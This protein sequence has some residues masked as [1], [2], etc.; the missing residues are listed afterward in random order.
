MPADRVGDTRERRLPAARQDG[1][2]PRNRR[3]QIAAAL[4]RLARRLPEF[5]AEAVIDS[6]LASQGLRGA[7]PETAARL[8]LIAYA[9]HVFTDYDDLLAEGYDRDSAR[10]FVLDEMNAVLAGW[11]AAP[12][13]EAEAADEADTP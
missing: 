11:G 5:E 2:A 4:E 7:A 12:I 8:A 3:E 13:P 9:R 6:A 1:G 10:H